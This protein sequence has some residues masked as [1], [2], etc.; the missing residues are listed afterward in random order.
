[1]RCD[2]A[3]KKVE[4]VQVEQS[5]TDSNQAKVKFQILSR[6]EA[7]RPSTVT[8]DKFVADIQAKANT[9]L[10]LK[11]TR[12][13]EAIE[14]R[15]DDDHRR[16]F[17]SGI[18]PWDLQLAVRNLDGDV[19]QIGDAEGVH[20]LFSKPQQGK[21]IS[22]LTKVGNMI[23]NGLTGMVIFS[24]Q[25][26][27]EELQ[28]LARMAGIDTSR[29]FITFETDMEAIY[30]TI[31]KAIGNYGGAGKQS[32]VD[33]IL[34]D[35][36]DTLVTRAESKK[37]SAED[38]MAIGARRSSR[39]LRINHKHLCEQGVRLYLI[40]QYRSSIGTTSEYNID[41]Y[42]GGMAWK[43]YAKT[44]TYVRR[45]GTSNLRDK[46]ERFKVKQNENIAGVSSTGFLIS[47]KLL[48]TKVSGALEGS[49]SFFDFYHM[50]GIDKIGT[51]FEAAMDYK[52]IDQP[53]SVSY[54][55]GDKVIKGIDNAKKEFMEN[56]DWQ[57]DAELKLIN[58]MRFHNISFA[59]EDGDTSS[60][61]L[62]ID[63]AAS[64][65]D[66]DEEGI[67]GEAE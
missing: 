30:T 48:K 17:V 9:S 29:L 49:T 25:E 62:I 37:G 7:K 43:H 57:V 22:M 4:D 1:M 60:K 45:A 52:C 67:A 44:I 64:P 15:L 11:L 41:N 26:G 12:L 14:S 50:K 21:T 53:S 3:K 66:F 6:P 36:F 32:V 55:F 39:F 24:E 19:I 42:A 61:A 16:K 56:T 13:D 58:N 59:Y 10:G 65:E 28:T 47:M 27:A 40:F 51:L 34:V 31:E 8:I 35:S 2:L 54:A 38:D 5:N 33:F 18:L 20:I 23:R 63:D 46:G